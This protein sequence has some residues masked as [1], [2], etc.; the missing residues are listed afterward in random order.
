MRLPE[1]TAEASLGKIEEPYISTSGTTAEAGRILPQG[2]V[3]TP[4][5]GLI[6]CYNEGGFS[7]CFTIR[8]GL[9]TLM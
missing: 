7:G 4:G 9:H 2:Y 6:Y 5:G 3:H 1:F 8:T